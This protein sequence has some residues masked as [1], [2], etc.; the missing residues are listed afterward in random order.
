MIFHSRV[1]YNRIQD[2]IYLYIYIYI[3]QCNTVQYAIVVYSILFCPF[4]F[5]FY[6]VL[7]LPFR[8]DLLDDM[9]VS[10]DRRW[11]LF[12]L[13][14]TPCRLSMPCDLKQLINTWYLCLG[15]RKL[16]SPSSKMSCAAHLVTCVVFSRVST[17]ASSFRALSFGFQA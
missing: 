9:I 4:L 5:R 15:L 12:L 17:R 3:L 13:V 8:Y 1:E 10:Y 16:Q 7:F 2:N 6:S 11:A 14:L